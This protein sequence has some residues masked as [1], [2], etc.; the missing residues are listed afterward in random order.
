MRVQEDTCCVCVGVGGKGG[1]YADGTPLK[2]K[3]LTI[4]T[5]FKDRPNIHNII[6]L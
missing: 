5:M 2:K 1:M 3:G 4:L 6:I